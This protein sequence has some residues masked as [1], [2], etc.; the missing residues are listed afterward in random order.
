[1][2]SEVGLCFVSCATIG[3]ASE[4]IQEVD[5]KM[6]RLMKGCIINEVLITCLGCG[7]RGK[8]FLGRLGYAGKG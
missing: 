5:E 1:M 4:L 7:I 2:G 3:S 6:P 8:T